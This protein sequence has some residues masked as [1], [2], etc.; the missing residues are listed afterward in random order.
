MRLQDDYDLRLMTQRPS[1]KS[2][3][4]AEE[5]A[6]FAKDAQEELKVARRKEDLALSPLSPLN[7]LLILQKILVPCHVFGAMSV[8]HGSSWHIHSGQNLI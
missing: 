5:A 8:H 7:R 3:A 4:S 2:M 6:D 1:G